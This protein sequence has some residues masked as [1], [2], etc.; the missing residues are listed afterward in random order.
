[1]GC[2]KKGLMTNS[3]VR[4]FT[5][6]VPT[7]VLERIGAK[8]ALSEVGYAPMCNDPWLHGMSAVYLRE[9]LDYWRLRYDW[10]TAER[11]LNRFPQ[12]KAC[13]EGVDLHFYHVR[14]ASASG[15]AVVLTHG[16]PGSVVEF[17]DMIDRFSC[18]EKH[19]AAADEGFDVIVPSLPGYGFSARPA[20]PIGPRGVARLWRHLMVEVLG[21]RRFYAQ[22]G[23]W[24]AAVT[25]WLGSDH[26]DVV[27]AIHVNLFLGAH[28]DD[29]SPEAVSWRRQ[30]DKVRALESGYAH[31]QMTFPQTIGLAL[32]DTPLGFAAWV[33]EKFK[34][35]SDSPGG[36]EQRFNK[37]TL[38]TNIMLYL[39]NDAVISSMWMYYGAVREAS[40]YGEYVPVPSAV[41][42]FPGEFLPI[43]PRS[44][45]ERVLNLQRWTEMP[46]GGHFAALEEPALL[47]D[48]VRAFF[49]T[50]GR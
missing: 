37:D 19:G 22:G 35:W 25:C 30:L 16:W 4:P 45:V 33:L 29:S 1:M 6:N 5:V 3:L 44:V 31:Q 14:S 28:P 47:A 48:D 27:G 49:L 18:P 24:G 8:L 43:P 42:I 36:I 20:E 7:S 34:R 21:Y 23:D 26:A 13:V 9:F 41:A 2:S 32:A 12:F 11:A 10:R 40:R 17:L 38:L 39:V 15:R 46:S 50:T